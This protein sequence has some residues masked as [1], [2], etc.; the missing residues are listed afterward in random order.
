[1]EVRTLLVRTETSLTHFLNKPVIEVLNILNPNLI[2]PTNLIDLIIDTIQVHTMLKETTTRNILIHAM[3]KSEAEEFA[4]VIGI[5]N[6]NNAHNKLIHTK[7]KKSIMKKALEYFGKELDEEPCE[8]RNPIEIIGPK[9]FLF[10]HQIDTIKKARNMLAQRP[11]RVL[12]HMPTGSGKTI[13]A[14][15]IVLTHLLENPS[16]LVIWLAHNEELCEQ[17]IVEFQEMWKMAGDRKINT[18]RFFGSNKLDLLTIKE[19]FISAGLLKILGSAK[20]SNT[21]LAKVAQRTSLVI[22]DE[23]HQ[24]TAEK[25]S[26]VIDEI[27][28]V[29]DTQLLG[30]SATPGR[31]SDSRNE[32]NIE[33]ARFFA[34]S[35][36]ML[37]T[38]KENPVR[39]L[40]KRGYLAEPKFNLI[41][42]SENNLSERDISRIKNHMDIPEYILE[43]L[44]IDAN[45]NLDIVQEV[46]RLA[47]NHK[48]IIVFASQI[49]H[50]K[51]ISLILS[52]KKYA[53]HY[54]TSKTPPGIRYN[55]LH[56]YRES[57][58]PMILCNYGILA[59]G[60]DAPKTSAIVIARPTKS[61]VLY[62]Q[63]VGRGM[64]GLKAGGN[65]T[66]EISTIRDNVDEF[67][68]VIDVFTQWEEAWNNE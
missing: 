20:K 63:M 51:S 40:I 60:F 13:S 32:A 37:D 39:F 46:M 45:R 8:Q 19:G 52:A 44:S 17:A 4:K 10:S 28:R 2:R 56:R 64:R 58:E 5:K 49:E 57:D 25:F 21:F 27:S 30:L 53:S 59:A 26:I 43:K 62:A 31:K 34:N 36:V 11:H 41:K 50:A 23:A 66:C 54:I 38:K 9:R 35:K 22:I 16:A 48:K 24:A 6:W 68:N 29:D 18:Y 15:R 1:M 47:K 7:F 55:I 65:K 14:M 12:L 67:I 61:Y 3:T 42:Y 33:L